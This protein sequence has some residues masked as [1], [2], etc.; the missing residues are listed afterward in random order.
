MTRSEEMPIRIVI[1]DDNAMVRRALRDLLVAR[2]DVVVGEAAD[3]ARAIALVD[4]HDPDVLL[5]DLRMPGM[6]GI[7]ACRRLG[8]MACRTRI[9]MLS[10]H[11]DDSTARQARDVGVHEFLSKGAGAI[12]LGAV[13]ESAAKAARVG[14]G[15]PSIGVIVETPTIGRCSME[16]ECSRPG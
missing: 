12:G 13:I 6:D 3:G 14:E 16:S 7:E 2:G 15:H 9:V 10:A 8:E 5:V 11:A 1:A 4:A